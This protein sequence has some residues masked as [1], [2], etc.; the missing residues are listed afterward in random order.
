MSDA[1]VCYEMEHDF[2]VNEQLPG[3]VQDAAR[4][5]EVS[6]GTTGNRLLDSLSA[7]L[8][9]EL[10]RSCK[11][12][13]LPVGTA[14]H[15]AGEAPKFADF[16]CSG[17]ASAVVSAA[18]GRVA[19]VGIIGRE[20]VVGA[21]QVLGPTYG[22]TQCS[23]QIEATSLRMRFE[24]FQWFFD[25]S[26]ELRGFVLQFVQSEA[27][28]LAQL[29]ACNRLHPAEQR[30]ARFLLMRR[31][32][33]DSP[34]IPATHE[35]LSLVLGTRRPAITLCSAVLKRK[36]LIQGRRGEVKILAA[37]QLEAEACDCYRATRE[38]LHSLYR[39]A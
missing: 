28:T 7:V 3:P 22:P 38:M 5:H 8:R 10:V 24:E 26:E 33:T 37:E 14:L 11:L 35:M 1:A 9:D 20:G 31:D 29:A 32:R 18:D 17:I 19:E 34:V 36:G 27:M 2:A 21:M 6:P 13:V 25:H 15:G 39:H 16:L 12:I 30:L 23:I 4:S